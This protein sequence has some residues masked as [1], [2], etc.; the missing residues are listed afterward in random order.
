MEDRRSLVWDESA[1]SEMYRILFSPEG[2]NANYKALFNAALSADSTA[3][4]T[5][6]V[7]KR[8]EGRLD[9][10]KAEAGNG[11][12][13]DLPLLRASVAGLQKQI[14]NLTEQLFEA[15]RNRHALRDQGARLRNDA[16]ELLQQ[17]RELRE[18][19]LAALFPTLTDTGA[20]ALALISAEHGCIVCGTTDEAHLASA[21]KKLEESLACPLC[22]ADRCIHEERVA[23]DSAS[24]PRG[25][26][27]LAKISERQR[28]VQDQAK[29][30]LT[31]EM[32]AAR[33]Y[34]DIQNKKHACE[35]ELKVSKDRLI[36]AEY[37]A[38]LTED[39][40]IKNF[41]ARLNG[42]RDTIADAIEEKNESL[43]TLKVMLDGIS[44]KVKQFK[45]TLIDNFSINIKSFLAERC[46]LTYQSA[47][48]N[49]GQSAS[50]VTLLF[51]EFHVSMTS[52][53][54]R[55]TGTPRDET[56]SVSESQKEFI[57]LAFRMAL[58]SAISSEGGCS[59]VIETPEANLDAVFIPRAGR[60][61][62]DFA[63]ECGGVGSG[64]TV[65][66]SSNLNGSQMIPALLGLVDVGENK[67]MHS[68]DDA[69][70]QRVLNL[71]KYAAKSAALRQFEVEYE[72][73]LAD[74]MRVQ[75]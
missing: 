68:S 10:L 67:S 69:S 42:F 35:S 32:E 58:L 29:L 61:L 66:A 57:E 56:S 49:V 1:Q 25:Q 30:V 65:I 14:D 5:Q 13:D 45:D 26:E 12:S 7:L 38:G 6:A 53:V 48:R 19:L 52:G 20:L 21:K 22:G 28:E 2:V 54:F 74:A 46:E 36:A 15:D 39:S 50:P 43:R 31:Q 11:G 71:L 23:G 55:E 60:A 16:E 3:R 17:E 63:S 27:D 72:E 40:S 8:E 4:N 64:A 37:R 59:L 73:K 33:T 9:K 34:L 41:E 51:P 70:S 75:S 24:S 44:D 62:N 47:S 18:E